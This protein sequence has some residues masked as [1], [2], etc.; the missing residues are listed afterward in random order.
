MTISSEVLRRTTIQP[1][2]V[3]V[4]PFSHRLL[5]IAIDAFILGLSTRS[6]HRS[7]HH[8]ALRLRIHR[9]LIILLPQ[10]RRES[11]VLMSRLHSRQEINNKAPDVEDVDQ[12][13]RPLQYCC[14]VVVSLVA[15]YAECNG[16][17]QLDEDEGELDPEGV[18]ED[19]VF[20]VVDSEALVFGADE[21]GGDDIAA[22]EDD[23]HGVVDVRVADC[24]EDCEED[25]AGG[26]DYGED[27]REYRQDLL[28]PV[29][30]L[31]QPPRMPQPPLGNECHIKHHHRNRTARD[32]QRLAPIPRTNVTDVCYVLIRVERAVMRTT[33]RDPAP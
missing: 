28:S 8:I 4:L 9:H 1:R 5:H 19:G 2:R 32:K 20:A 23:E 25:Q 27:C 12:A 24:V 29:V 30:I 16:K 21:D 33:D 18:G 17:G 3:E 13:Y 22:D 6:V 15:H 26:S 11:V 14:A 31:R 7:S 10:R